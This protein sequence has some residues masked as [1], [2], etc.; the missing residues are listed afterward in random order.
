[1]VTA[2]F[3]RPG[4]WFLTFAQFL[5]PFF[6]M[7]IQGGGKVLHTLLVLCCC[8]LPLLSNGWLCGDHWR[9]IQQNIET[10]WSA[11]SPSLPFPHAHTCTHTHTSHS[12]TRTHYLHSTHYSHT[13]T[14]IHTILTRTHVLPPFPA[15]GAPDIVY[16]EV[17]IKAVMVVA[18]MMPISMLRNIARL[19]KVDHVMT[20]VLWSVCRLQN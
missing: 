4:Y 16:D 10:N 18:V 6:G 2:A 19:E 7:H 12:H 8:A 17:L 20:P 9:H 15:P 14:H 1:M 5:F 11:I 3:G 13:H